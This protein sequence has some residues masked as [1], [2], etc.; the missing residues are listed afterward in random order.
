MEPCPII[1]DLKYEVLGLGGQIWSNFEWNMISHP[2]RS[3]QFQGPWLL[4]WPLL[5]FDRIE[6]PLSL[7][8]FESWVCFDWETAVESSPSHSPPMAAALRRIS[9]LFLSGR[10][11]PRKHVILPPPH[12]FSSR[13]I[14]SKL[15]VGGTFPPKK[16]LLTYHSFIF[17]P[18][19]L[20]N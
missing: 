4:S 15:F 14:A 7:S 12:F 1:I 13:G 19:L 8:E 10:P 5:S 17:L 6:R 18:H 11:N 9:G 2:H 16:N 20:W 3:I